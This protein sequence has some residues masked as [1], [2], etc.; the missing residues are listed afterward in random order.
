MISYVCL[1]PLSNVFQVNNYGRGR[2]FRRW[3]ARRVRPI[4]VKRIGVS[5]RRI[6]LFFQRRLRNARYVLTQNCRLRRE[7]ANCVT[8]RLLRHRK[9]IVGDGTFSRG[10]KVVD[11]AL[12]LSS[13]S[14]VSGMWSYPGDDLDHLQVF[15]G[16]VP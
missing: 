6:S 1:R 4:R 5:G 9:L 14:L 8:H 15:S 13:H 2:K 3:Q 11:G 10:G 7:G 12:G 16:P